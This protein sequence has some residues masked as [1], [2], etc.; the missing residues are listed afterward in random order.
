[1]IRLLFLLDDDDDAIDEEPNR[2]TTAKRPMKN[3]RYAKPR[4]S[5]G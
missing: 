4:S 1:M 2:T 5:I 3:M